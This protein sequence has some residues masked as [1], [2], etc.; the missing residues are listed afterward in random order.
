MKA[1]PQK[2]NHAVAI[3]DFYIKAVFVVITIS[4]Q[5][6]CIVKDFS[7]QSIVTRLHSKVL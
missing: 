2:C 4:S 6:V 5:L 7:L 1:N 3:Y